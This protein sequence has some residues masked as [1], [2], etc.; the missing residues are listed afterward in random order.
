[1]ENSSVLSG[2]PQGSVLRPL[3]FLIYINDLIN[4][5]VHQNSNVNMF[6]D[7]VLLYPTISCP[8][9]YL[10]AQHS[11]AA[12]E[13]WSSDNHLQLNALKCKCMTIS[14]KKE[15]ITPPHAL[16]LNNSTLEK[17]Q[18]YKYLGL[19]LTADLSWSSHISSICLKARKILGLLYRWFYGNVSQDVLKQ[20]YLS[21]V[22]P[23]LEYGCHVLNPHLEKDK[24]ELENVQEFACT[25]ATAHWDDSYDNL[26]HLLNL[27]SLQE[28]RIHARLGMLYRIIYKLS[29]YAEDTFKLRASNLPIR[30]SYH[31]EFKV[32]FALSNSYFY[33]FVPHPTLLPCG[34]LY[35]R[36][37]LT[38]LPLILHLCTTYIHNR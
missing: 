7:D 22:R 30:C 20:L 9:D 11:I 10:A 16:V 38:H 4:V 37:L 19:L 14:R 1:M 32:P 33:S 29:Y 28:H 23:H 18:S 3:P 13:H 8:D 17:V 25:I 26:L 36:I 6:A 2:V 15:P 24:R 27:Q 5:V 34:I 35:P 31:L 21:L 12:I